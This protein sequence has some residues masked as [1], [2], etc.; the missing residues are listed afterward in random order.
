MYEEPKIKV[1]LFGEKDIVRMS[2]GF[3]SE[4]S[5]EN[6]DGDEGWT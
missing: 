3:E 1:F 4:W 6:V 5:D 2:D